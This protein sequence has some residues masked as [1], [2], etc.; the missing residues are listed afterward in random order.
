MTKVESLEKEIKQLTRTELEEFRNWFKKYDSDAWDKQ[1]EEDAKTG[2]L[3]SLAEK[4]LKE[5]EAGGS[6]ELFS[7]VIPN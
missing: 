4:A 3:D 7:S 2:K 5:Y 6:K 1:I